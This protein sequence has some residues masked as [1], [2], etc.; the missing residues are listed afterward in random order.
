LLRVRR[1]GFNAL[2]LASSLALVPLSPT[3]IS[4]F[5]EH[6][7]RHDKEHRMVRVKSPASNCVAPADAVRTQYEQAVSQFV[8]KVKQ[9]RYILAVILFGSLSY[10]T[11]WEKSDIDLMLIGPEP[12]SMSKKSSSKSFVLTENGLNIHAV[13]H[14][15]S[16]FRRMIE[17][18]LRSSFAHSAFSKSKLLFSR[19]PS[20]AELYENIQKMGSRDQQVQ[21][22]RAATEVLP[23]LYKAQKWLAVRKDV[24]Y[25][26]LWIMSCV[27][28]LAYVEV[29]LEG[30]IAGREVIQQAL[31][32][33]PDFF[34]SIYT[35]LISRKKTPAEMAA[36]LERI[37]GYLTRKVRTL[38][39]PI[40]EYLED[41]RAPRSATEIDSHFASQMNISHIHTACEWLADKR[42]VEKLS[43]PMRL[44][45]R[46]TVA[47]DEM[48][49]YYDGES[50]PNV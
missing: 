44:T 49:F 36:A 50:K 45:E 33:N 6:S 1:G 22:L 42:M 23:I 39:A 12:K 21:V 19:D 4:P 40:F 34:N 9:D 24:N 7:I 8:E 27:H 48:A 13:L 26:F 17:G 35:D 5:L 31:E 15:R 28:Q 16:E 3:I 46:S 29:Y 2:K 18:S 38:F 47:V 20:V 11:V 25:C 14:S 10:D 30:Q 32:L 43:M 41:A 37:D